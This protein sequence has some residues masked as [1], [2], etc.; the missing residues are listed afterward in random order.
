[1]KEHEGRVGCR[2]FSQCLPLFLAM[3]SGL[4]AVPSMLGQTAR[5]A[6]IQTNGWLRISGEST[7]PV[8]TLEASSNLVHWRVIAM[9]HGESFEFADP[10]SVNLPNRFYRFSS[11]ALTETNDWKNQIDGVWDR[12]AGFRSWVKFAIVTDDP[13]RVYY[14]D[15]SDYLLHYDFVT[16]RLAPFVGLDPAEFEALALRND[17]REVVLGAVIFP[18][19]LSIPE[20]GI[21]FISRDPLSREL[22]RDLFELVHSTVRTPEGYRAFYFPSFEQL[23]AAEADRA[24]FETNCSMRATA[25]ARAS[26]SGAKSRFTSIAI[27]TSVLIFVALPFTVWIRRSIQP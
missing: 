5:L 27:K 12:F 24:W 22:V 16:T 21:Q 26:L 7:Q 11:S 15:G 4:V 13:T 8:Q 10:V 23:Q 19:P 2:T 14:A 9:L 1:M 17:G 6:S 20:Y 25:P 18:P 3:I